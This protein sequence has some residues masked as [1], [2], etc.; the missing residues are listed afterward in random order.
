MNEHPLEKDD[1]DFWGFFPADASVG[2]GIDDSSCDRP[3]GAAPVLASQARASELPFIPVHTSPL[4]LIKVFSLKASLFE[5]GFPHVV[6]L[7]VGARK[8]ISCVKD[9]VR[10]KVRPSWKPLKAKFE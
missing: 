1:E 5:A 8:D 6:V 7:S 4:L 2:S 3:N 10:G 9:H